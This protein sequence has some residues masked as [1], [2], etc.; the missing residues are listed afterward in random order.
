[1]YQIKA[2]P[3]DFIVKEI[4]KANTGDN[5]QYAYFLLKKTNYSTVRA[6]EVLSEKLKIPLKNFGFAGN[7]DK[8]AVTEQKISIFRGSKNFGNFEFKNVG[9]K[10]LGNGKGP[11]SLGDLEGNEFT[12]TIRDL[13]NKNI[14]KIQQSQNKEFKIPNLYGQ[15]RFSKNNQLI[16]KSVIK[17]DFKKAIE[18]ILENA[19]ANEEKIKGYLTKNKNNY[20]EALRLIP[21]KTRKLFVHSYQSFLFN[22]I[23][24]QYLKNNGKFKNIKIP[25][26]GFNFELGQIKNQ[27]LKNIIKQTLVKEKINSRDFVISQV[28]ELTSE[29][30]FRDLFFNLNIKILEI[31]EDELNE[32]KQKIRINF[33]LPKSCYATVALEYIF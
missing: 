16:G 6:L 22:K 18:L 23:V 25:I 4:S 27:S 26:I 2:V 9:L 20:V 32:N 12:I 28:P 11:I 10:Y 8:N 3:E 33:A 19:G 14:K 1:M 24:S 5:G 17:R 31:A 29:G 13:N 30:G 7:K 21:L 15:Q